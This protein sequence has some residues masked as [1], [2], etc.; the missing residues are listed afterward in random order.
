[1]KRI[2]LILCLFV[3]LT[4]CTP[5]E[6]EPTMTPTPT[7]SGIENWGGIDFISGKSEY[8]WDYYGKPILVFFF[9]DTCTYCHSSAPGVKAA[10][11]KYK[12]SKELVVFCVALGYT[13]Q[14]VKAFVN[15]YGLSDMVTIEEFSRAFY[16]RYFTSGVPAFLFIDKSMNVAAK[17]LG[18]VDSAELDLYLRT[19]IL[20]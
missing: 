9:S 14:N 10:F 16:L 7:P 17:K 6:V 3:F 13:S 18:G 19:T 20:K 4:G 8:L 15:K 2:V 12:D 11:D 5:P 1:M